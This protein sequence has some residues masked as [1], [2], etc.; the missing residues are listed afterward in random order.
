MGHQP[1]CRWLA[2]R[3][4]YHIYLKGRQLWTQDD[5]PPPLRNMSTH[6]MWFYALTPYGYYNE[7]YCD[8]HAVARFR[9]NRGSCLSNDWWMFPLRRCLLY[10]P[11]RGHIPR[12]GIRV[13][14]FSWSWLS[15]WRELF[16]NQSELSS[17]PRNGR[18]GTRSSPEK[19]PKLWIWSC[20]SPQIDITEV[21]SWVQ[22]GMEVWARRNWLNV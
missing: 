20:N 13:R 8:V 6:E 4:L 1:F 17:Y 12:S 16:G 18:K 10:S 19:L 2:T 15:S 14:E 3:S 21:I 7:K 22:W 9:G 11:T 5:T